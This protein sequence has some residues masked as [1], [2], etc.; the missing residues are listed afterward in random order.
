MLKKKNNLSMTNFSKNNK[1]ATQNVLTK[2]LDHL[3]H[4]Q[5]SSLLK[6]NKNSRTNSNTKS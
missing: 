3:Q 6:N 2:I 4:V 5:N 1:R